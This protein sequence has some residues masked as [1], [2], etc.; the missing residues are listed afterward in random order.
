MFPI[1]IRFI[2]L[3]PSEAT[4]DYVRERA[5]KLGH[6]CGAIT[7]CRVTLSRD[8]T[9]RTPTV[10]VALVAGLRGRGTKSISAE[11]VVGR[12]DPGQAVVRAVREAFDT[13]MRQF[14]SDRKSRPNRVQEVPA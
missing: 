7:S 10:K 6:A 2:D 8:H 9:A 12:H 14:V 4:E 11:E 3:Q 5:A 13:A 1:D